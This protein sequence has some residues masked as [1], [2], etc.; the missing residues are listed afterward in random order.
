MSDECSNIFVSSDIK[1]SSVFDHEQDSRSLKLEICCCSAFFDDFV[2]VIIRIITMLVYIP[3]RKFK[4]F[5]GFKYFHQLL[6]VLN[7]MNSHNSLNLHDDF[8]NLHNYLN[9]HNSDN[10][11]ISHR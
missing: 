2:G 8:R 7:S 1:A 11:M 6:F 9:S 5:C 3:I 10:I 4:Y